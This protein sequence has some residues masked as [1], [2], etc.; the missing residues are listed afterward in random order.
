MKITDKEGNNLSPIQT[1]DK[2]VQ[3][4]DQTLLEIELFILTLVGLIPISI[5]RTILYRLSGIKIDFSSIINMGA[6]LYN[7]ENISIGT[8]SVVGEGAILDGRDKL[9]IGSHVDIASQVMIY[10][11]EHDIHDPTFKA[12]EAPVTIG[13]Y[14]FIGPR[15]IILPGVTIGKGAVI[16]A[17]AVVTKDVGQFEIVGGVPAKKIGERKNTNPSYRLRRK[18]FFDVIS[19]LF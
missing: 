10:N 1:V 6:R 4:G 9:T 15:A 16:G 7:P 5:I 12:T 18:D 19:K 13:D 17:G 2:V 14:V 3:R 8:D 11:S